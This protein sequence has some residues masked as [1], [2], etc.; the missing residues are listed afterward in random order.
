MT[1]TNWREIAEVVGIVSIVSCLLLLALELRQANSI[2][3]SEVKLELAAAYRDIYSARYTDA[4]F[5]QLFPKIESPQG[6]LITAT[7]RSR[8]QGLALNLT[9]IYSSAQMAF[10]DGLLDHNAFSRYQQE[11]ENTLQHWP[12]L[13]QPFIDLYSTSPH[14]QDAS[15]FKA[16]ADL[17]AESQPEIEEKPE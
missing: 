16:L 17:V 13:R 7:D 14:M 5:A 15:V 4:D 2:A 1:H 6:H 10:D 9:N 12:G 3:K 8:M 11:L